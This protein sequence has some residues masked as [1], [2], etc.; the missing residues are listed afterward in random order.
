MELGNDLGI[1][2]TDMAAYVAILN[3]TVSTVACLAAHLGEPPSTTA[4]R[5]E[6]LRRMHWIESDGQRLIAR[7]PEAMLQQHVE[8]QRRN[9]DGILA[10]IEHCRLLARVLG[11]PPD[12]E[13]VGHPVQIAGT[14]AAGRCSVGALG[15]AVATVQMAI[16]P[17]TAHECGRALLGGV[18]RAC[19]QKVRVRALVDDRAADPEA[20]DLFRGMRAL[21][22][23]V[24]ISPRL[25]LGMLVV[26]S[27]NA[28]LLHAGLRGTS[29][30]GTVI[31]SSPAAQSLSVLFEGLWSATAGGSRQVEHN[32][33]AV[34]RRTLTLLANGL[35]DAGIARTLG[36]SK[37]TVSRTVA[38]L[39]VLTT[40]RS[41]FELG[42]KAALNG[43]VGTLT[44]VCA[45]SVDGCV[46]FVRERPCPNSSRGR[47]D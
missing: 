28:L 17:V 41:R 4:R 21:D 36:V 46:P 27:T 26:D 13:E 9:I 8:L 32:L 16:D 11:E 31:R 14:D 5:A 40:A 15:S 38:E 20:F 25:H 22:V 19:E 1:G 2:E 34:H 35:T 6:R 3:G 43:W 12:E 47:G 29:I 39:L 10:Q 37:R 18:E 33:S 45:E 44:S 42:A 23:E 30:E 7:R 24:R